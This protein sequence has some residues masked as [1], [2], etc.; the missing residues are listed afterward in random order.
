MMLP[1]GSTPTGLPPLRTGVG[2]AEAGLKMMVGL[3]LSKGACLDFLVDVL[4]GSGLGSTNGRRTSL[5]SNTGL[6]CEQD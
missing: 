4:G 6:H 3:L 1:A 2:P 5:M